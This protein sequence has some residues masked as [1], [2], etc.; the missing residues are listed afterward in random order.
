M[1]VSVG[2]E[3]GCPGVTWTYFFEILRKLKHK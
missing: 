3:W 1:Y 2:D